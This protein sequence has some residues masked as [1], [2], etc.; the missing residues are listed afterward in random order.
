MRAALGY[1]PDL[2]TPRRFN[3]RLGHKILNDRDPLIPRSLDKVAAR[4]MVAERAGASHLVP[5]LGVY[6]RAS[7]V[8][9]DALPMRFVAKA[10][11]GSGMNVLVYD[12]AAV[13]R[14]AVLGRLDGWL[15]ESHYEWT[16][17]WGYRDIPPR[18]VVEEMSFAAVR[19]CWKYISTASAPIDASAIMRRSTHCPSH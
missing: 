13:D 7:E 14:T 9:W 8:P 1:D 15:R 10:S 19:G 18:I 5:L 17:E 12:K 11:H 4:Q 3:E 16:A 2:A 6:R